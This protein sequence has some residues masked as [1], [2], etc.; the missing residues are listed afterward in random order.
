MERLVTLY[1]MVLLLLAGTEIFGLVNGVKVKTG[2]NRYRYIKGIKGKKEIPACTI[3]LI[4]KS[5][6]PAQIFP[7]KNGIFTLVS[8]SCFKKDPTEQRR[9]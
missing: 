2:L 4:R 3:L 7:F 9:Y 1:F 6:I 5:S 8:S